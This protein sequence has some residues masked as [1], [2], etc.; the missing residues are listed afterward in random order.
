MSEHQHQTARDGQT[1]A[2]GTNPP[3]TVDANPYAE[4]ILLSLRR[5]IRAVDLYNRELG[6]KWRL[7]VPQ[8][9]CLRQLAAGGPCTPGNLARLVFLSQATVTGILNRL[10]TRGLLIREREAADRRRVM[11]SLTDEGRQVAAAA[12]LPLQE[13]FSARFNALPEAE[14]AH[15]DHVLSRVVVMMEVPDLEAGEVG[16]LPETL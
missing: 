5:I 4:S 13:R 1:E 8:L 10:E 12:P 11:V 14:Q 16:G 2:P 7:T 15:L 6:A 3:G 9:V